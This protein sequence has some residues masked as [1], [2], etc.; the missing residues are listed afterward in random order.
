MFG[1]DSKGNHVGRRDFI[2]ATTFAGM[3][4]TLPGTALLGQ[5]GGAPQQPKPSGMK[6]KLLFVSDSPETFGKLMDSIR[7]VK[8][9]EFLLNQVTVNY[10]RP[11]EIVG[12]IRDVD[13]DAILMCLPRSIFSYGTLPDT[14]GNPGAPMVLLAQNPDLI[15]IDANFAAALRAGGANVLFATSQAQAIELLKAAA[16]PR[17]LEG[18]RAV[19]YGR[20]FDSTSV[21]AH[22]LNE[23]YVYQRTGVRI[24]YRPMEELKQL[25]DCTDEASARKEAERWKKESVAVMEPSDKTILDACRLYVLLRSTIEKEGLSGV[26]ID[27]LG[28]LF[29]RNTALPYPCLSFSRLRDEGMTAACEADVCAMLSSMLL[30][31]IARK[32]SFLSNVLS[33][34]LRE[35]STVLSHCVAPLKM[36]GSGAPQLPYRLRD[37]HGMGQGVVPEVEFPVGVEVLTGGFTKDLKNFLLWS[38]RINVGAKTDEPSD[39][40]SSPAGFR[41]MTCSNY[42][43]LKIRDV[44]RFQQ[45]IPGIHQVVITGDHSKAIKDA[46]LAMNVGIIE[47]SDIT[48]PELE[49]RKE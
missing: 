24:Q 23:N 21:P 35:S 13:A 17:I 12:T 48:A 38:G 28:L 43:E 45:N 1:N 39:K 46:L 34:D 36:M 44:H 6:R 10:Q 25:F 41:R 47:P 7:S 8:E 16:A 20:P 4:A 33:V 5:E 15:L 2:K 40:P 29:N 42:M 49:I 3:A 32:P 37:Y 26:S 19:I 9:V 18:K 31:E 11:Q 27:C 30:Q 14:L 22:N